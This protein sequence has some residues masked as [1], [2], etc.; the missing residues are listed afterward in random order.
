MDRVDAFEEGLSFT[1]CTAGGVG[2]RAAVSLQRAGER[3]TFSL[4]VWD[5]SV[6][7]LMWELLL[8][9]S[10]TSWRSATLL[11]LENLL[12]WAVGMEIKILFIHG[13]FKKKNHKYKTAQSV[14][15]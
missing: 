12:L 4:V 8:R 7:L 6:S 3:S 10:G 1:L 15:E 2:F 11:L 14:S 5:S 13:L 9:A